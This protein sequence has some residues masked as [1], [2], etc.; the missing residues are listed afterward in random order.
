MDSC[1]NEAPP[2]LDVGTTTGLGLALLAIDSA[3]WSSDRGAQVLHYARIQVV[4][5]V[6]R[7]AGLHG[8]VAEQAEATGWEVSWELLSSE[9][10]R[11]A[12]HPWGLVTAAVRRAVLGELISTAFAMNARAAWRATAACRTATIGGTRPTV[13]RPPV[14]LCALR[15]RGWEP[16]ASSEFCPLGP[17]VE[18]VI[19]AMTGQGWPPAVA[20]ALV[21]SIADD[22]G[23]GV[24]STATLP[25]WRRIG[26]TLGLPA[27]QVRRVSILLLGSPGWVGVV[28][29]IVVEGV[30]VLR[31]PEVVLAFRSTRRKW[32]PSP[33]SLTVKAT[34][35]P[36]ESAAP[37]S[38]LAS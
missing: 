11:S 17:L 8:P 6:I 29:R 21:H 30:A 10:I 15:E 18:A 37:G 26:H 36:N 16:A 23:P 5:P 1:V 24:Q 27:W 13:A 2:D 31:A 3:G 35:A 12:E 33:A 7:R 9:R 14:S 25:G 38:L 20:I 19:V 32:L 28:E 34:K 4:R 22:L